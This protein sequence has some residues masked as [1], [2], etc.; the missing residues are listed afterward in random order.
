MNI[1]NKE[2]IKSFI[3]KKYLDELYQDDKILTND[4]IEKICLMSSGDKGIADTLCKQYLHDPAVIKEKSLNYKNGVARFLSKFFQVIGLTYFFERYIRHQVWFKWKIGF[5]VTAALG[6]SVVIFA[7]F[8]YHSSQIR[9]KSN[10]ALKENER[11]LLTYNIDLPENKKTKAIGDKPPR[12]LPS[13]EHTKN[14]PESQE[15]LASESLSQQA[16]NEIATPAVTNN[17]NSGEFDRT[18]D[19]GEGPVTEIRQEKDDNSVG[20][21]KKPSILASNGDNVESSKKTQ[22]FKKDIN[23]LVSQHSDK[24]VLQLVSAI[25]KQTIVNYLAFFGDRNESI[26]EFTTSIDGQKHYILL[27]GPFDNRDLAYA[28]IE[29][30]P[31]KV[32]QI[33]PWVR[34]IKSIKKLVE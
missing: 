16:E 1:L 14:F 22:S 11:S 32:R 5:Y 23:W 28:Q 10:V 9:E 24:Y 3:H 13:Y 33:K 27:Y 20:L 17:D 15:S 8:V 2:E 31:Q 12:L 25:K 4:V 34:T 19:L 7:T 26:I 30:L 29:K 18:Q 21:S 6:V